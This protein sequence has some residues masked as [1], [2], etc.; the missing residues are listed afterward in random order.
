MQKSWILRKSQNEYVFNKKYYKTPIMWD[1]V[2]YSCYAC[3]FEAYQDMMLAD[4]YQIATQAFNNWIDFNTV[5]ELIEQGYVIDDICKG[6]NGEVYPSK[7]ERNKAWAKQVPNQNEMMNNG[8][9]AQITKYDITTGQIEAVYEDGSVI[10][11]KYSDYEHKA[12]KHPTLKG[13]GKG[14]FCGFK[15][16]KIKGTGMNMLQIPTYECECLKCGLNKVMRPQ[17]MIEHY[18]DHEGK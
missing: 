9:R 2:L 16:K 13:N 3:L 7:E 6:F 10:T 5:M 1:G 8:V 18:R 12:L 15:T 17:E 4:P 14:K 11:G